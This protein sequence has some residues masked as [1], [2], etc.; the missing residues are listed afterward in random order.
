LRGGPGGTGGVGGGIGGAGVGD[1]DGDGDGGTQCE[2]TRLQC[3]ASSVQLMPVA[4]A[5]SVPWCVNPKSNVIARCDPVT[6]I[7]A[8]CQAPPPP[9]ETLAHDAGIPPF[10]HSTAA[11][12]VPAASVSA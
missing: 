11:D 4:L 1:G 10:T 5:L 9:P 3:V 8:V 7:F 2:P 6:A 12:R